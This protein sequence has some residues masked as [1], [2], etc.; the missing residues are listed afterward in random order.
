MTITVPS[1][2]RVSFLLALWTPARAS[3]IARELMRSTK[4]EM[5][6]RGMSKT[7]SGY[8]PSSAAPLYTM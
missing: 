4:V 1:Q 8:G 5:V 3:T 7:S 6:V 2:K